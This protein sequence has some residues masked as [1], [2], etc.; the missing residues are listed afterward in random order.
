[1]RLVDWMVAKKVVKKD[2]HLVAHSEKRS[3]DGLVLWRVGKKVED[4]EMKLV[5]SMEDMLVETKEHRKV[6]KKGKMM[7]V[8]KVLRRVLPL[9]ELLA[10]NLVE[11]T[12][13]G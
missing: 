13:D 2:F 12:V 7:V 9:V 1:M 5:E 8:T 6:A 3:V 11:K 10:L 4:L